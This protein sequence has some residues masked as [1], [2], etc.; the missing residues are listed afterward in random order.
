MEQDMSDAREFSYLMTTMF[1]I[2]FLIKKFAE[3]YHF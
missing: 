2:V 1:D 3:F